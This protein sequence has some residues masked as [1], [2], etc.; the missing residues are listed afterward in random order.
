VSAI[1]RYSIQVVN[2]KYTYKSGPTKKL[3]DD[4]NEY[5]HRQIFSKFWKQSK[6]VDA[7]AR[8]MVH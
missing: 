4:R 5:N 6:K 2:F 3:P 8:K 7:G 1:I